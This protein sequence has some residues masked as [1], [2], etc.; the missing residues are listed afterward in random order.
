MYRKL[1]IVNSEYACQRAP[2]VARVTSDV[3][4][5]KLGQCK[6]RQMQS[7]LGIAAQTV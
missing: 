3:F 2:A 1:D 7:A 5:F 6:I 4:L